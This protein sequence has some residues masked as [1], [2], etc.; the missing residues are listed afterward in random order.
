MEYEVTDNLVHNRLEFRYFPQEKIKID[1][2]MRNRLFFGEAVKLFNAM[3]TINSYGDF[4]GRDNGYFDLSFTWAEGTSYVLN[5][6]IDRFFIDYTVGNLQARA[7]RHRI[8]W[9]STC[10]FNDVFNAYSYF[11]F[12]YE[13][14]PGTDAVRLQYFTGSTSSAEFVYQL[15]DS[16]DAMS[17]MGL[18]RFSRW[19]Y[20]IQFLAGQVKRDL[21]I[22]TGWSGDIEGGGFRGEFTYF[23]NKDSLSDP[24][25]QLVASV[26]GDYTF[27]NS[28]YLQASVLYNSKGSTGKAGIPNPAI[29]LRETSAKY[30]TL[31]RMD[32]FGQNKRCRPCGMLA[33]RRS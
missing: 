32:L 11:D 8:N 14:R 20:D 24:V 23:H 17:F 33:A 15:G 18:Y 13:E 10:W 2:E 7:G 6:T 31:S 4:I 9:G 25:G 30:L 26:S 27:P 19:Q 28:L 22:G 29:I 12:D 21:V 5:T 3:D 16:I 1:L